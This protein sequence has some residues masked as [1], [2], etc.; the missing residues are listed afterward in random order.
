M[1]AAGLESTHI[2]VCVNKI[3][4][5]CIVPIRTAKTYDGYICMPPLCYLSKPISCQPAISI[6]DHGPHVRLVH[7]VLSASRW[8]Q[9]LAYK[10]SVLAAINCKTSRWVY[11]PYGD[12]P[13]VFPW[14]GHIVRNR[15]TLII[16]TCPSL[17]CIPQCS[18]CSFARQ[19]SVRHKIQL[20]VNHT[21]QLTTPK[22]IA[23]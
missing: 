14:I 3:S 15:H 4:P 9:N 7:E 18:Y 22:L 17:S 19:P 6:L 20:C 10:A 23:K 16:N 2:H 13:A 5:T 8:N 21:P 11:R 1:T 12:V